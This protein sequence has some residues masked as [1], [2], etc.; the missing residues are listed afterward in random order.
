MSSIQWGCVNGNSAR[1]WRF[2]RDNRPHQSQ[3]NAHLDG[4]FRAKTSSENCH[5]HSLFY[6]KIGLESSSGDRTR[7]LLEKLWHI[8]THVHHVVHVLSERGVTAWH[9]HTA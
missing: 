1:L 8:A 6:S 5:S 9:F 2:R 3:F 7:V 4:I